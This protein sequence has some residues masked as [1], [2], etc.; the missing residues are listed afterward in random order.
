MN[1]FIINNIQYHSKSRFP[2]SNSSN[3]V[4]LV[5]GINNGLINYKNKQQI[6]ERVENEIKAM[7]LLQDNPRFVQLVDYHDDKDNQIFHIITEYCKG[8][9]LE[10]E[11]KSLIDQNQ[12]MEESEIC[13]YISQLFNILLDLDELE[14]V[15]CDIKPLNIFIGF[16]IYYNIKL[17]LGDFGCC[18]FID[19]STII[20]YQDTKNHNLES[21][22]V[23]TTGVSN[24]KSID[25]V[26]DDPNATR[27]THGFI[28]PEAMNRQY[29]Q[30]SDIFSIGS[31]ILKLLCCHQEDQNNHTLFQHTGEIKIS[32]SR[33]S[34]QLIDLIHQLL[35]QSPKN[36]ES[37]NQLLNKYIKTIT[38]RQTIRFNLNIKFRNTSE[39][40]TRIEFGDDFNQPIH[41][42]SLP[43]N[44]TSLSIGDFFN[45][46]ISIDAL[47]KSLKHLSLGWSFNQNFELG[48]L[49]SS[50][51]SLILLGF[52]QILSKDVFP[53]SLKLLVFGDEFNQVLS[54]GVLPKSLKSLV[55]GDEF[56]QI[57][58]KDVLPKSLES[59]QFGVE[60]NQTLSKDVLPKSLKSLEFGDEFNQTLAV[61]V[62]P[63]SL[64]S[65]KFGDEFNQ[66]LSKGELP[67]SLKT[68]ELQVYK[69]K[70]ER[71]VLPQHLR[72]LNFN[73]LDQPL[74]KGV[75]PRF[76]QNLC[77]GSYKH[78][79][80]VGVLP[81]S[82]QRL[83]I[84]DQCLTKT[85]FG[86]PLPK[87]M[88][89]LFIGRYQP[90]SSK[91]DNM[92]FHS[93]LDDLIEA[94]RTELT[95]TSSSHY[96]YKFLSNLKILGIYLGG[97][98]DDL[99]EKFEGLILTSSD[100]SLSFIKEFYP[101]YY[102]T[103]NLSNFRDC[104]TDS[105][106][107]QIKGEYITALLLTTHITLENKKSKYFE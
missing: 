91:E 42:N 93:P 10:Q 6:Y 55:F 79:I 59:M 16:D 47:P 102:S 105:Q 83:S 76:L 25:T 50:L 11:Y 78:M 84:F 44:L 9:D 80:G 34:K 8:G 30:S 14:I 49:P 40:I 66:I 29:A 72:E 45:Q 74:D 67:E 51:K 107:H 60:F 85:N 103:H 90:D 82:L 65:L 98:F 13:N 20:K 52:N 63:K 57:L 68:L 97:F 75:L 7:K 95:S 1:S 89:S 101:E 53:K 33:Y 92:N 61:G 58:S 3:D 36:R 37:I 23:T 26:M 48:T 71:E 24:L 46:P 81:S 39:H 27:G 18:K 35:D 38:D 69:H 4:Y 100:D 96:S 104:S 41:S 99:H 77:L 19:K 32:E 88:E 70:I 106:N 86:T 56:N 15:H 87:S 31:T 22:V 12:I 54:K 2:N 5:S 17:I 43:P 94:N 62:L 28:S 64:E 21:T 73:L